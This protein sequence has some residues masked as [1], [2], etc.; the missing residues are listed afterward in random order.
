[1]LTLFIY[2]QYALLKIVDI[3]KKL[4]NSNYGLTSIP[5]KIFKTVATYLAQ[6][7]ANLINMS[8][9]CG[10]F[11]DVL[12]HA[13]VIP[14]FKSGSDRELGNYRPISIL[15]LLSKIFER[16]V[17]NRLLHFIEKH[18]I[19]S[20]NQF[21]FQKGK[22]TSEAVLNFVE[23]VYRSENEGKHTMGVSVDLSK[24]FDTVN[25]CILLNKLSK[26]GIRGL[27][28]SWFESYLS[29][30]TQ[31]VRIGTS[32]SDPLS[33]KIGVPQGSILGPIL[34]LLYI[35]DL[36]LI[37]DL[38][39]YTLFADDTT[40]VCSDIDYSNLIRKASSILSLLHTWTINNRLSLNTSKT[41]ALLFTNRFNEIV[42]PLVLNVN[43]SPIFFVDSIK[44]LGVNVD[45]N[46][47]YDSHVD[48]I[49]TKLAKVAGILYKVN[50]VV[51]E[52]ILISLY[53]SL[54]YPYLIYCV[55][56]WGDCAPT[57]L[58]KIF[59]IQKKIIRLIT[60]SN[61]LDHTLP[62]FYRTKILTVSDIYKYNLGV[63][64][65]EQ[66]L[67]G[68]IT[69]PNH[70]HFTRSLNIAVP[71]FQRLHKC[72][73]SLSFNGPKLWNTIPPALKNMTNVASFKK[74]YR[75]FLVQSYAQVE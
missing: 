29:N 2:I 52:Y 10:V 19:L 17:L 73:K 6:P 16:S 39:H 40:V 15:P 45:C 55:L 67:S 58:N 20:P 49:C 56:I 53:Y 54:V 18:K 42:T 59:L 24:A 8:F 35:N 11:P 75:S 68:S 37:S 26:Y 32:V 43:R 21:G 47:K 13:I 22:S 30:R 4:K 64:M 1:M 48:H 70:C 46:L 38:A 69:Y 27:P 50:K 60:S 31:S 3:V 44:F 7:V 71:S 65:F 63:Y 66:S 33:T 9:S 74:T 72:Q 12:K 57:H 62:L 34:F 23:F 14:V 51:P 61:Y 5:T 25:H 28:L 36:P 41:S